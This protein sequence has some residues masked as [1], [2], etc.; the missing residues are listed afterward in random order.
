MNALDVSA[1]GTARRGRRR[2]APLGMLVAILATAAAACLPAV[3]PEYILTAAIVILLNAYLAQCWNLAAG[4]AGQFSLGHPVFLGVGAYTS[5]VLLTRYGVSP[6]IGC[7]AGAALA[8]LVGALLSALAFRF[9]VKG[10]FFAVV[11]LSSAE[12]ARSLFENWDFVGGTSGIILTLSQSPA[13]MMFL[14]RMPYY[15]L[16]L[17]MVVALALVT[18]GL[19]GSR[20][21]QQ[22]MA[23]REDEPAAEAIGVRTFRS[24]VMIIAI[25][26]AFTALAGTFYAQLLLF[27]VPNTVFSFEHMMSMMLGTMI[28]GA[29][30]VLGPLL[31]TSIFG[32]LSEGLR[33]L[34][35]TNS[36]EAAS[37]V[38]IL[39]AFV[40]IV[41]VLRL[42]GGLLSLVKRK[43]AG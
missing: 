29:G 21:G 36:R 40:L 9:K 41:I 6:W 22:L 3:L 42:P 7:I 18:K 37:A 32:I 35:Y 31:G 2:A 8:A 14:S 43:R 34:P 13:N 10:V 12:V 33:H 4:Y 38:K 26:A 24:K 27:I 1:A 23:L 39:Y 16:V 17:A 25:S 11:T 15:E 19:A 28:G 30:T 20:F 5:T